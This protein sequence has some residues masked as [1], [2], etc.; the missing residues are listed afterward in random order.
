VW[1]DYLSDVYLA[2]LDDSK[3]I[4]ATITLGAS[5]SSKYYQ[6]AWSPDGQEL[7]A[8]SC[9]YNSLFDDV[10]AVVILGDHRSGSR[11]KALTSIRGRGRPTWSP[12]GRTIAF[13]TGGSIQWIKADGSERGLVVADGESPAWR[14]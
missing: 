5:N 2:D 10:C 8:T 12:D 14:P 4:Q 11:D 7:A 6:P 1:Y 9:T 3:I 13:A